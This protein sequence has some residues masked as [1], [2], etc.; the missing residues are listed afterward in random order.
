MNYNYA[1]IY[2]IKFSHILILNIKRDTRKILGEFFCMFF[3]IL[4][5]LFFWMSHVEEITRYPDLHIKL[6]LI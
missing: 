5:V 1:H 2:M 6:M 4:R 3:Y